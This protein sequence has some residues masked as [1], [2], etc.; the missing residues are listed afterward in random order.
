MQ[1]GWFKNNLRIAGALRISLVA[2]LYVTV[3]VWVCVVGEST[4]SSN[5][6][7]LQRQSNVGSHLLL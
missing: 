1:F 3:L 2:N 7:D 5:S 4:P 6:S